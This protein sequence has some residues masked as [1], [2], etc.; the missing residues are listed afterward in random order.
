MTNWIAFLFQHES[1]EFEWCFPGISSRRLRTAPARASL[2]GLFVWG[3]FDDRRGPY[4]DELLFHLRSELGS[5]ACFSRLRWMWRI[6]FGSSMS[7][8]RSFGLRRNMEERSDYGMYLK[9]SMNKY[10]WWCTI[11]F[12]FFYSRMLVRRRVGKEFAPSRIDRPKNKFSLLLL[13]AAS[14][15]LPVV[16]LLR[17]LPETFVNVSKSCPPNNGHRDVIL[18]SKVLCLISI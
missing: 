10:C 7:F 1:Q 9:F 18:V 3:S 13:P 8:V 11:I 6:C 17:D 14:L 15:Y 5:T 2:S 12:W 16:V 4:S